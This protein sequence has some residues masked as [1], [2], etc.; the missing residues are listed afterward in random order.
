MNWLRVARIELMDTNS[1]VVFNRGRFY[2]PP[3][4]T[5]A[6]ETFITVISGEVHLVSRSQDAAKHPTLCRIP[7]FTHTCT[8]TFAHF[9][10]YPPSHTC[11]HA[12][13]L[14]RIPSF[15]HMCTPIRQF[16]SPQSQYYP[17]WKTLR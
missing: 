13:T 9:T 1:P 6:N 15:T 7:S 3:Q 10:G 11:T 8:H 14:F 12:F 17:G 5:F 16:S 4:E 2:L